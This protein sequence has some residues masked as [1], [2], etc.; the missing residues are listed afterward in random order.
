MIQGYENLNEEEFN[1]LI[2]VPVLI[3]ILIGEADSEIDKQEVKWGEKV[4]HFRSV[5]GDINVQEYYK[6]VDE[7]FNE[8]LDQYLHHYGSTSMN[9]KEIINN[10]SNDL[11][12]VNE[13]LPKLNTE[14]ANSLYE[15]FKSFAVHIAKASGGIFQMG[16]ISPEEQELLSLDMINNPN[17]GA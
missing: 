4:A 11:K 17:Q 1:F 3:T 7:H 12:K 8:Y 6:H 13:V 16:S 14:L 5:T 9:S 2:K 15:S 10:V